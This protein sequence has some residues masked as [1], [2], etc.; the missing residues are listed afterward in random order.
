MKYLFAALSAFGITVLYGLIIG[1]ELPVVFIAVLSVSLFGILAFFERN[2]L[3]TKAI[4]KFGM[5]L[6][7]VIFAIFIIFG[8]YLSLNEL[9]GTVTNEYEAEITHISYGT[10]R[11]RT[12]DIFFNDP[13]GNEKFIKYDIPIM[14]NDEHEFKE[15]DII[16][17]QEKLGLFKIPYCVLAG[18][19][20][21]N[22]AVL[23]LVAA[24]A[25]LISIFAV[26]HIVEKK[27][28]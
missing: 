14:P 23:A 7:F 22:M 25:V 28:K 2:D 17:V 19:E 3:E 6:L 5:I 10:G 8:F 11:I 1:G 13:D 4:E 21:T 9:K 12:D 24:G 16:P 27:K 20:N 15:G 18:T 26:V